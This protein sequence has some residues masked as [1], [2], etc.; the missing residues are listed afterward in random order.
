MNGDPPDTPRTAL[1][2]STPMADLK[3]LPSFEFVVQ[4][5][6]HKKSQRG[7][8]YRSH[9]FV[10]LVDPATGEKWLQYEDRKGHIRVLPWKRVIRVAVDETA[11]ELHVETHDAGTLRF[12]ARRRDSF[13]EWTA[14]MTAPIKLDDTAYVPATTFK[15]QYSR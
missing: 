4:G 2:R 13:A 1:L 12:R 8:C 15:R 9:Y 3:S 11:L 6:L 14:A 7:L 5:E 10:M